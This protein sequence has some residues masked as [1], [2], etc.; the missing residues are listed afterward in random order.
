MGPLHEISALV[1]DSKERLL[2]LH[3]DQFLPRRRPNASASSRSVGDGHAVM[4]MGGGSREEEE[5]RGW[6]DRDGDGA[7]ER[8]AGDSAGMV[9]GRGPSA[10]SA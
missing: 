2:P 9:G 7:E 1:V 3:H 5:A 4:M 6:G 8:G 10:T